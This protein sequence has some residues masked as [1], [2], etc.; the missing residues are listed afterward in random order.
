MTE[1]AKKEMDIIGLTDEDEMNG[2]MRKH[3]LHMVEEFADEGHSGF[4]A[5][6][7]LSILQKVLAYKPLSPLTGE[8]SEWND[9]ADHGRG[10]FLFQNNRYSAVFKEG[11]DGE[12]YDIDGKVFWDWWTDP[13]TGER[14]KSYY[15][16]GESRTP[17]IFPYDV[18]ESP[19]YEY[20]ESK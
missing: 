2:A 18:P 16:C 7:A 11:K 8:D 9:V 1:F 6:Y 17:V 14:T 19:I 12:A 5:S 20:R 10:D 15:S 13:K 3:I 4:S